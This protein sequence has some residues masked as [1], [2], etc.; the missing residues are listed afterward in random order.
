MSETPQALNQLAP[1]QKT[2]DACGTNFPCFTPLGPCWCEDVKLSRE[3]L[4]DLRARYQDCLCPDCLN[5]AA[6][7]ETA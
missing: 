2:C 3:M 6:E 4:A 7:N 1:K 5:A